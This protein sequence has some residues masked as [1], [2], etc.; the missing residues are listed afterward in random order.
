MSAIVAGKLT[1]NICDSLSQ[2]LPQFGVAEY[3]LYHEL[4]EE[5]RGKLPT[6][7]ELTEGLQRNQKA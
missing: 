6:A 5:L 2:I 4:P 1:M 3:Q 7:Q